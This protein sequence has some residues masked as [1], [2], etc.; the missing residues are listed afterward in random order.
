MRV[1]F[2]PGDSLL[3]FYALLER[4]EGVGHGGQ[5][6]A[7]E[8]HVVVFDASAAGVQPLLDRSVAEEVEHQLGIVLPLV[9]EM[10]IE[11]ACGTQDG[12]LQ[13]IVEAP[14]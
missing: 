8:A 13:V 4:G 12:A 7:V 6:G 2:L 10:V 14:P 3:V 11:A 5:G 9:P 1:Q